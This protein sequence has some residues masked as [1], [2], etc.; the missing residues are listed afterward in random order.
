MGEVQSSCEGGRSPDG[1]SAEGLP[2]A[3]GVAAGAFSVAGFAELDPDVA[4]A[5]LEP[6]GRAPDTVTVSVTVT[7]T[8]PADE[9]DCAATAAAAESR[10]TKERKANIRM[11]V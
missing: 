4:D 1:I 10:V 7:V 9:L 2:V 5:E 11:F 3:E 6:V 8:G